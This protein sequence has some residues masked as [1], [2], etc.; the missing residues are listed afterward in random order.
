MAE[1]IY[2]SNTQLNLFAGKVLARQCIITISGK[3]HSGKSSLA[4]SLA[5]YLRGFGFDVLRTKSKLFF[6]GIEDWELCDFIVIDDINSTSEIRDIRKLNAQVVTIF[7]ESAFQKEDDLYIFNKFDI[8]VVEDSKVEEVRY[9]DAIAKEIINE[10]LENL[11][12]LEKH[13]II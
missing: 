2:N 8:V 12:K 7:R 10:L 1:I 4:N 5:F 6:S 9:A 3:P 11:D 13:D